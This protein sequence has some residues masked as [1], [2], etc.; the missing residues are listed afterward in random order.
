[1]HCIHPEV[2]EQ[3][4][5]SLVVEYLGGKQYKRCMRGSVQGEQMDLQG[6][7]QNYGSPILYVIHGQS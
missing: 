4:I 2:T 6:W 3:N 5:L 1:M 7:Y